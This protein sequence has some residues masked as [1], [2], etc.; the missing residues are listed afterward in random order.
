M[1]NMITFPVKLPQRH[2]FRGRL[3]AAAALLHLLALGAA[4]AR[5]HAIPT[6]CCGMFEGLDMVPCLQDAAGGNISGAC[7]SSLNRGGVRVLAGL[8]AALPALPLALPLPGCLLYAPPLASCQVPVQE[9]TDAAPAAA[10]EAATG[11]VTTV[12]SPPPQA[13]VMSP[14]TKSKKR[15][16]DGKAA[17]DNGD[18]GAEEHTSRSDAHRRDRRTNAGEGIRTNFPTVVVAMAAFWFNYMIN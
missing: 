9:Q 18:G 3:R 14:S 12:D 5:A 15:S 7:C 8:A 4:T 6:S 11:G 2:R 1:I 16:A 10:A 17:A 13:A